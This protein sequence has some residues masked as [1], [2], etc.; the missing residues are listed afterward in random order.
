MPRL[1]PTVSF[2]VIVLSNA[3]GK[4][5]ISKDSAASNWVGIGIASP[6][7]T[8]ELVSIGVGEMDIDEMDIGQEETESSS[9]AAA[10]AVAMT[11]AKARA[12]SVPN[13]EISYLQKFQPLQI[14]CSKQ[15]MNCRL[16]AIPSGCEV[17]A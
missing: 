5:V 2:V 6:A 9:A 10:T 4:G 11:C 13:A 12:A 17:P 15:A 8:C 16:V 7:S 3:S 1:D 14:C